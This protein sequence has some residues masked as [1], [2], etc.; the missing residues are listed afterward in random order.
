LNNASTTISKELLAARMATNSATNNF[1]IN[2]ER[3]TAP[4]KV[5][6]KRNSKLETNDTTISLDAKQGDLI[7]LKTSVACEER[8]HKKL[9]HLML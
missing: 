7:E 3:I 8:F 1:E 5:F 2:V 4:Y 9:L 6:C